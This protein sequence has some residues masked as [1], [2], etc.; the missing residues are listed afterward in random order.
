MR[1]LILL[2]I[3]AL[4]VG[5]AVSAQTQKQTPLPLFNQV[6]K[7]QKEKPQQA[8]PKL[9][10]AADALVLEHPIDPE[11]YVVGAGDRFLI[12]IFPLLEEDF[13]T[14]ITAE[15][16]LIV[17]SLGMFSVAGKT[18]AEM[19]RELDRHSREKY[20]SGKL[21][22]SL[23]G[24]RYFRVHVIGAVN[25]P[26][27]YTVQHINRLSDAIAA[28]GGLSA[29][30]DYYAIQIRRHSGA[31]LSIDFSNYLRTGDLDAN[32]FLLDG[33]VIFIKQAGPTLPKVTIEGR[34]SN[35][36]IHYARP[37][38]TA[39]DLLMRIATISRNQDLRNA[40]LK[41]SGA[42][43]GA[44]SIFRLFAPKDSANGSAHGHVLQDGDI[45][46]IPSIRDSVYVQGAVQYPG[47]YPFH[48]GFLARDYAG[49]A[50]PNF[51]SDGLTSFQTR[52]HLSGEI[53]SGPDEPVHAGD[54]VEVKTARRI[55]MKDV[56]T[57]AA[58]VVVQLVQFFLIY[59][60]LK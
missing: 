8:L 9:E 15:G 46:S 52:H 40:V 1:S 47:A 19:Q 23:V 20:V 34:F 45:I 35:R 13:L 60:S 55:V 43:Q 33:D 49:L 48:S 41:R 30:A 22:I 4:V 50:G 17:P 59:R 28:A 29:A 10:P 6:Q 14:Q 2:A 42:E 54:T 25:L 39:E 51:Q 12:S 57:S 37:G 11:Q 26:G 7:Q 36:G 32:P 24:L 18:L 16:K 3:P 31:T 56:L 27:I 44:T 5:S 53:A 58:T 21:Q 38:E